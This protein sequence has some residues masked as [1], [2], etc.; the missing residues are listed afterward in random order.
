[1]PL[2]YITPNTE[3]V[4]S[5]GQLLGPGQTQLNR[6]GQ[7]IAERHPAF[8]HIPADRPLLGLHTIHT[9]TW[10]SMLPA[11]TLPSMI[12]S[13]SS[14][15]GLV[16]VEDLHPVELLLQA[17]TD[18]EQATWSLHTIVS[19]HPQGRNTVLDAYPWWPG[20]A[21]RAGLQPS[22]PGEA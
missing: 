22:P 3:S 1:M 21:A 18:P 4:T 10:R 11:P 20:A 12:A 13:S 2:A 15:E 7:L 8:V 6:T 5:A 16:T 19:R 9:R 14:L 17:T